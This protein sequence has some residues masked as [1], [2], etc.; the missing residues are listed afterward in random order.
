MEEFLVLFFF[1]FV[2]KNY[3]YYYY[4][5]Y[6]YCFLKV[7]M[8]LNWSRRCIFFKFFFLLDFDDI[9]LCPLN[10]LAF[11]S[12]SLEILGMVTMKMRTS[13]RGATLLFA[14]GFVLVHF[15][16][17]GYNKLLQ[18]VIVILVFFRKI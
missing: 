16:V 9:F 4:Y 17:I 12:F 2:F 10:S 7:V 15:I 5:Y 14:F 18:F 11:C 3:Y 1:F 13:W 8:I 6:Y